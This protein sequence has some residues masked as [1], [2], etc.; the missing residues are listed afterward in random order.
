MKNYLK[1][2][3][4]RQ[5]THFKQGHHHEPHKKKEHAMVPKKDTNGHHQNNEMTQVGDLDL[6]F[7]VVLN[8]TGGLT[9][10]DLSQSFKINLFYPTISYNLANIG[11]NFQTS[12]SRRSL[13][14]D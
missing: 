5:E 3:K 2:F 10:T 1:L 14:K 9:F 7:F 11:P 6:S 13:S 4:K 12:H 8:S